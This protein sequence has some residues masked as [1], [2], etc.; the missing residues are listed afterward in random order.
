MGF[1][2]LQI[3]DFPKTF[4]DPWVVDIAKFILVVFTLLIFARFSVSTKKKLI[5]S[6]LYFILI[7]ASYSLQLWKLSANFYLNNI[8]EDYTEV[9]EILKEKGSFGRIFYV[10][11]AD[12]LKIIA[13]EG[14]SFSNIELTTIK[15]FMRENWYVEIWKER[16]GTALIHDRFLDNRRG[17]ILCD[18][19]ECR[20]TMDSNEQS[21][22]SYQQFNDNWYYFYSM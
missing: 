19:Q 21:N 3:L 5:I 18:N 8:R 9:A 15:N 12:S 10:P 4:N 16:F 7:L 14:S 20:D 2:V 6:T 11:E 1:I 17:F 22:E 13:N